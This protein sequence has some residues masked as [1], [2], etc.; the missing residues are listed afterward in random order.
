MELDRWKAMRLLSYISGRATSRGRALWQAVRTALRKAFRATEGE[1]KRMRLPT[2]D[3]G[4]EMVDIADRDALY[5]A[6]EGQEHS[7]YR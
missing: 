4:G 5:N 3:G 7:H 2:F 6:M 1:P